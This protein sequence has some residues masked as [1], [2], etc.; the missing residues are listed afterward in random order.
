[1]ILPGAEMPEDFSRHHH[2]RRATRVVF[3]LRLATRKGEHHMSVQ[4]GTAFNIPDNT[5]ASPIPTLV[6]NPVDPAGQS[7]PVTNPAYNTSG[8]DSTI[9]ANFQSADGLTATFGLASPLKIGSTSVS[10]SALNASG[11]QVNGTA[12]FTVTSQGAVSVV[13]TLTLADLPVSAKK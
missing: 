13:F 10:W 2:R 3:T 11:A 5:P 4:T 7:A 9:I 6:A 1:M 12:T 8:L